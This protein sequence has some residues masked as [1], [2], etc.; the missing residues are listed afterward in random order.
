MTSQPQRAD[1]G[2]KLRN[3]LGIKAKNR[4]N[5]NLLRIYLEDKG[6]IPIFA[7]RKEPVLSKSP[8][9]SGKRLTKIEA[10]LNSV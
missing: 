4:K 2:A 8:S 6:F 3:L 9:C 7:N 5:L 10:L 1:A